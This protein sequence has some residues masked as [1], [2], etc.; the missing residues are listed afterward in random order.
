MARGHSVWRFILSQQIVGTKHGDRLIS[1]C[2]CV[3]V[4]RVV[5]PRDLGLWHLIWYLILARGQEE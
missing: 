2:Q 3:D 1:T 4:T 5:R